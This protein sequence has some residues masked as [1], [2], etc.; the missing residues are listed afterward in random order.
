MEIDT[1]V[2]MASGKRK[3]GEKPRYKADITAGSLKLFESRVIADLLVKNLSKQEWDDAIVKENILQTRSPKTAK[4]LNHLLKARLV[5]WDT[6]LWLMVRDGDVQL[7]TQACLASAIK[8]SNLLADFFILVLNAHY[9][10]FDECLSNRDWD[11][12]VSDCYAR[13][14]HLPSWSSETIRRLKSTVFQILA[15][16]GYLES[17][18][19]LRLQAVHIINDVERY[20]LKRGEKKVL[21]CMKVAQ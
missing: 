20:L 12:F 5:Q 4:R 1:N 18:K 6:E 16:A 14:P 8:H 11:Q 7:A 2:F 19:S 15:Q 21:K 17:T 9:R 13:D 3:P 10:A